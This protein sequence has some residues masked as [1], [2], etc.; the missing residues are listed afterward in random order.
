MPLVPTQRSLAM[1]LVGIVH[2]L[3]GYHFF[4]PTLRRILPRTIAVLQTGIAEVGKLHHPG[5]PRVRRIIVVGLQNIAKRSHRHRVRVAGILENHLRVASVC[6]H[7][8]SESADV[9]TPIVAQLADACRVLAVVRTGMNPPAIGHRQVGTDIAMID[10][11]LAARSGHDRVQ[12]VIV[13]APVK[14]LGDDHLVIHIRIKD[15]IAIN[16]GVH[17]NVRCHRNHDDIVEHTDPHRFGRK[18]RPKNLNR[19]GPPIV[20][21]VGQNFNSGM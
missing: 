16:V 4:L 18:S 15:V 3:R 2:N 8:D 17:V 11:P 20:I 7:P 1:L 14:S 6:V 13:R 19:V 9:K 12:S 5:S 21:A 10:V